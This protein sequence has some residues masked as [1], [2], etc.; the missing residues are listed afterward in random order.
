MCTIAW[1][2]C[3][4]YIEWDLKVNFH[5]N[6]VLVPTKKIMAISESS[7]ISVLLEYTSNKL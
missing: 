3:L 1:P 7:V 4:G 5:D 2:I 6:D